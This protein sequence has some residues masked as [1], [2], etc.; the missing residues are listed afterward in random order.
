MHACYR[1][2]GKCSQENTKNTSTVCC[3]LCLKN[4]QNI[5]FYIKTRCTRGVRAF[6]FQGKNVI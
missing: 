2:G 1:V 4:V 3:I 6:V 5:D